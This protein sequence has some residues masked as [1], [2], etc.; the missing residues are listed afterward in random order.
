MIGI[1]K[2][3]KIDKKRIALMDT[4]SIAFIESLQNKKT[5]CF[6]NTGTGII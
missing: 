3:T 1:E 5:V 2:I 4:S 6:E